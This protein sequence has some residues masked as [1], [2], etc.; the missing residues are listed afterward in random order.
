V[1]I[2]YFYKPDFVSSNVNDQTRA[3]SLLIAEN[4]LLVRG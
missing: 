4:C 3:S 1:I 2:V